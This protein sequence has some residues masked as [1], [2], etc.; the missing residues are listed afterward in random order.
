MGVSHS[1][2]IDPLWV[3]EDQE[4]LHQGRESAFV[5]TQVYP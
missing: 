2:Q 4:S 3:E 1:P 5:S